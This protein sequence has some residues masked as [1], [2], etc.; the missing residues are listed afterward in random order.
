MGALQP[1]HI[2]LLLAIV[3]VV[4]FWVALIV[5]AVRRLTRR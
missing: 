1:M 3:A 2:L 4:A 5:W